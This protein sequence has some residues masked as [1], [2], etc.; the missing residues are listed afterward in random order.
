MNYHTNMLS[1]QH[2]TIYSECAHAQYIML[3][4]NVRYDILH[5]VG[6]PWPDIA[7]QLLS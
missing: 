3:Q 5:L 4:W 6:P 7:Q 2:Y 1:Q